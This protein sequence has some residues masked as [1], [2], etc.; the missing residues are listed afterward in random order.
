MTWLATAKYLATLTRC[1]RKRNARAAEASHNLRSQSLGRT[2]APL[3][4]RWGGVWLGS[5]WC[6]ACGNAADTRARPPCHGAVPS[7]FWSKMTIQSITRTRARLSPTRPHA[8]RD[9][10]RVRTGVYMLRC[11]AGIASGRGAAAAVRVRSP[12]VRGVQVPCTR[13]NAVRASVAGNKTAELLDS[14]WLVGAYNG[15][16]WLL[17][18]GLGWLERVPRRRQSAKHKNARGEMKATCEHVVKAEETLGIMMSCCKGWASIARRVLAGSRSFGQQTI[19]P[20]DACQLQ[21]LNMVV[22]TLHVQA[23][24]VFNNEQRG[25]LVEAAGQIP[26]GETASRMCPSNADWRKAL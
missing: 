20:C 22:R 11:R 21:R 1:T 24:G 9:R 2:N 10:D 14:F 6:R 4:R 17:W 7:V 18:P 23:R 5:K 25:K 8:L 16:P 13:R 3:C 19:A 26:F 15:V 12:G